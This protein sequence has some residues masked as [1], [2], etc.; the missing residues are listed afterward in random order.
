MWDNG[1]RFE[2]VNFLKEQ[3]QSTITTVSFCRMPFVDVTNLPLV[4]HMTALRLR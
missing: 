1:T 4:S 2:L 3:Q